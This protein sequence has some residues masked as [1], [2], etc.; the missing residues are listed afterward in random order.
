VLKHFPGHGHASGDS[1]TGG[2]VT[3]SLDQLKNLDLEPYRNLVSQTPV[4]VMIGHMVVPDLTDGNPAS[5]SLQAVALLRSGT[6][7]GGP[8]FDGPIFTDDLSTMKAITD[9]YPVPEAVLKALQAGND[10]ALWVSDTEV[11]A[12]LDRLVAALD[13]HELNIADIDASVRRMAKAKALSGCPH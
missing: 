6:G 10:N 9:R 1:H 8:R 13:H 4:G 2:V 3:P 11:P 12:V 5:L 7:Y